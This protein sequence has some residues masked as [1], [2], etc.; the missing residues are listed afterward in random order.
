MAG[1]PIKTTHNGYKGGGSL[2]KDRGGLA[3]KKG[4]KILD[5]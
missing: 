1:S 5:Q 3:L 4:L 2:K